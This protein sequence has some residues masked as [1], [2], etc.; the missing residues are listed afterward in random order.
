M[1]DHA[2]ERQEEPA[3]ADREEPRQQLGDLHARE[4]LLAGVRVA[5][6]DAEAERQ[7]RDVGKRLPRPDVPAESGW[8]RCRGRSAASARRAPC[9]CESST[10]PTT[11]PASAS[12]GRRSAFPEL[13]LGGSQLER[14]LADLGERLLGRFAR[15]ESG[16]AVRLPPGP[17]T[18]DAHLEEL[19]EV[20][21]EVRAITRPLEQRERRVRR[22]GEN[23]SVV[24]E[25]GQLPVEQPRVVRLE[26]RLGASHELS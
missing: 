23:P 18:G 13:R 14:A 21:R 3:L 4:A 8:G 26:S 22:T 12:A 9:G 24:V 1:P 16:R 6:E 7:R 5:D 15:R 2:L 20:R 11:T 19:V 25:P 17:S 10:S